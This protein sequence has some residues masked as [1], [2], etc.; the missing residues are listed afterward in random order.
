MPAP[1]HSHS[2]I[3]NI[4]LDESIQGIKEKIPIEERF[5]KE[6]RNIK[7][8]ARPAPVSYRKT[9]KKKKGRVT[10]KRTLD[11]LDAIAEEQCI[12]DNRVKDMADLKK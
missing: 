8:N 9:K 5:A 1:G 4:I 7:L 10:M 12:V 11:E 2:S 3:E 6:S